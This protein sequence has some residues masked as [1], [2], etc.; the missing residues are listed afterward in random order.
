[1]SRDEVRLQYEDYPY[2]SRDPAE[3]KQRLIEGS[4]SHLLEV[5][6]YLFAGRADFAGDFQ[7]LVAGGGTGDAAIMLAQQLADRTPKG[8]KGG[9]VT[10][11]DLA[12]KTRA[13]AQARA[14]ARGLSN[15]RFVTGSLL[16][17]A[18]LAP[19]PYDYIDCCGVLHH[20]PEP[21]AGLRALAGVLKPGGGLGLMLYGEYGRYGVYP[22]QEMLRAIGENRPL[23]ERIGQARRLLEE[24]PPTH[25]FNL[26][27]NL[28][29]HK[30]GDAELVDLLLHSQDRAYR[31]EQVYDLIAAAPGLSLVSFIKPIFYRPESYLSDPGLLEEVGRL[32]RAEREAF[33][34]RLAGNMKTHVFYVTSRDSPAE[35]LA[36]WDARDAVPVLMNEEGPALAKGM[37]KLERLRLKHHGIA[38]EWELPKASTAILEA[39]DGERDLAAIHQRLRSR[40]KALTYEKFLGLYRPFFAL[41]NGLNLLFH[42]YPRER[43]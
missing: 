38:F 41:F 7:V 20:L 10:Y 22:V 28:G 33:A 1:M 29:D 36:P 25:G 42:A 3:E 27:R 16:E 26:N 30:R 15:I 40:N 12:G 43:R 37:A 14:Q 18:D 17:V 24:L 13:I 5:D 31:V 19:G 23:P 34:E 11:L 35:A 4:P 32:E 6:H 21:E 9:Q 39:I 2:P 8:A